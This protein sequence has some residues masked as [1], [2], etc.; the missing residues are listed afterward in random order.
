MI[1]QLESDSKHKLFHDDSFAPVKLSRG[2]ENTKAKV[3]LL[4]AARS[5][6]RGV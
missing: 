2:A 5:S 4:D 6:G 3:L 1:D